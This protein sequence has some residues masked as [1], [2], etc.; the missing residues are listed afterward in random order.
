MG[1]MFR[2]GR[3]GQGLGWQSLSLLNEL[4]DIP[5][6]FT[7]TCVFIVLYVSLTLSVLLGTLGRLSLPRELVTTFM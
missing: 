2:R 4:L 1:T 7:L 3:A 6:Q 5:H